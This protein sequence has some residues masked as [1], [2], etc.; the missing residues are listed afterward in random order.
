ML[1]LYK[2]LMGIVYLHDIK[3]M[4]TIIVFF[5]VL[6]VLWV[7]GQDNRRTV[8]PYELIEQARVAPNTPRWVD[9]DLFSGCSARF[10]DWTKVDK[11]QW[12]CLH[13]TIEEYYAQ[14]KNDEV[15]TPKFA[16]TENVDD[17]VFEYASLGAYDVHEFQ[18]ALKTVLLII[19]HPTIYTSY[20]RTKTFKAV[21]K[22]MCERFLNPPTEEPQ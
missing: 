20:D 10:Y 16:T 21:V 18:A 1:L 22:K 11:L 2:A 13:E 5:I 14:A 19:V 3:A 12:Q 4:L 9:N 6:S 8:D 17:L 7:L 15:G